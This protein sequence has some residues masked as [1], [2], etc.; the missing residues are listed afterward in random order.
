MKT[1]KKILILGT[2]ADYIE[3]L[4]DRFGDRVFFVT[5]PE[6]REKWNG[7][8]PA[9]SSEMLIDLGD[10]DAVFDALSRHLREQNIEPSGMVCFDCESLALA[11][12]IAGKFKLPF[13]GMDPIMNCRSKYLSKKIWRE[14]GIPCP[15]SELIRKESDA[16]HF[17]KSLNGPAVMKPLTGSGSEFVFLCKDEASCRKAYRTIREK[18][19][20][21]HDH[22]MYLPRNVPAGENP[23]EDVVMEQY[24][25]GDEYSCDFIVEK[26]SAGIIRLAKK[27]INRDLA[28]GTGSAYV[29]KVDLPGNWDIKRLEAR[30]LSASESLG[31]DRTIAM[32]DLKIYDNE[33]FLLE[34]TPRPG[35]DCLPFLIQASSGFDIFKATLDFA[36]GKEV[37]VPD[38][39][40]WKKVVGLPLAASQRGVLKT[41]DAGAII[42]DPRVISCNLKRST[43]DIIELPPEDY[44]SHILG[45]VLF[46]PESESGIEE[47]CLG[48]ARKLIIE[49]E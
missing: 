14:N 20:N 11:S 41:L 47:Q 21:H 44:R 38:M 45:Y 28:F 12:M 7:A 31:L 49:M 10:Q 46:S 39:N 19:K 5:D 3:L 42:K 6:E 27:I 1:L 36:E 17:F 40:E 9:S 16:V 18:V 2:T 23:M 32:V 37:S 25:P 33:V 34:I 13:T 15:E 4:L 8:K 35:G 29:L 30:L 24:I 43:G 22:R 26:G 48:I